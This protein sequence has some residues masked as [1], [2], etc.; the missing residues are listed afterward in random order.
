MTQSINIQIPAQTMAIPLPNL[1]AMIAQD[2]PIA[3]PGLA[4]LPAAIGAELQGG[5]YVG[6]MVE[7]GQLVHVIAAAKALGDHEWMKGRR[8]AAD[9]RGGGFTDWRLPTKNEALVALA[10]AKDLFDDC[11]HWTSTERGDY[12]WAVDFEYGIVLSRYRFSEFRVR[13]FRRL[14]I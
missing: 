9:H 13:P 10:H 6:P 7:D 12:P 8:V 5:I 14:S 1:L 4:G 11:W 3:A 2:K